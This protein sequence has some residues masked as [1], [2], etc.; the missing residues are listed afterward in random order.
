MKVLFDTL[1]SPSMATIPSNKL[2]AKFCFVTINN[3]MK[4]TMTNA[5]NN[6]VEPNA[7][8]SISQIICERGAAINH[9]PLT[10]KLFQQ[11]KT[12]NPLIESWR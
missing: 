6:S 1:E 5:N 7:W 8:K 3:P 2:E 10:L 11:A 9:H 4:K 12:Q